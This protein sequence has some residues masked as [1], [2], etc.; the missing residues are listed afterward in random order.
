MSRAWTP[1][2]TGDGSWTLVHGGHGEAC[3]S[4]E[5]AWTESVERYGRPCGFGERRAVGG[6]RRLLDV[7]TGLGLNLAAAL[8]L[9]EEA[10]AGLEA[11]AGAV[12]LELEACG[13]ELDPGVF[14]A[15]LDLGA[16]PQALEGAP[17]GLRRWW[18]PVL[19]ALGKAARRAGERACVD[20][21][22]PTGEARAG[23]LRLFVG[24]G[25]ETLGRALAG[26]AGAPFDAVFLDAFSPGR[27]PE[28]WEGAFLGSL[29]ASLAPGGVLSTFTVNRRVRACLAAAGLEVTDGPAVGRKR[30]GTLARRLAFS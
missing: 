5:G 8:A 9:L 20:I 13:L 29:A 18:P 1:L 12:A 14:A 28:L 30:A 16:R 17:R 2:E 7:G 3:H 22:T 15:A 26:G 27:A 25:R 4:R 19:A 10:G 24:D 21:R 6:V 23:S 11:R